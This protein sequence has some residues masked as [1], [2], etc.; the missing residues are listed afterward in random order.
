MLCVKLLRAATAA[1]RKEAASSLPFP[2]SGVRLS[3]LR[4]FVVAQCGGEDALKGLT[5]ADVNW[6]FVMPPT[7]AGKSSFCDFLVAP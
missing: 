2:K 5:T 7:L 3:Y 6:R 4:E 1:R